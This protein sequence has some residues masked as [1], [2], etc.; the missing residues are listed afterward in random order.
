MEFKLKKKVRQRESVNLIF[1]D[2][3]RD[4]KELKDSAKE[5]R[6]AKPKQ[7]PKPEAINPVTVTLTELRDEVNHQRMLTSLHKSKR[8][9]CEETLKQV[10]EEL[11]QS[12]LQVQRLASQIEENQKNYERQSRLMTPSKSSFSF[13]MK[14]NEKDKQA[15]EL[16]NQIKELMKLN[17]Q[18]STSLAQLSHSKFTVNPEYESVKVAKNRHQ[19]EMK[20][21]LEER[22]H[23]F[24]QIKK[25][26]HRL[27]EYETQILRLTEQAK[28]SA[29]HDDRSELSEEVGVHAL[30]QHLL[31]EKQTRQKLQHALV[32]LN[33]EMQTL[34]RK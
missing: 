19:K 34:K 25:M 14:K 32:E 27:Q 15:E 21:L 10:Q 13:L 33:S 26:N 28:Q 1:S 24:D 22:Q 30:Y 7:E 2:S 20:A 18:H 29:R 16:Q 9:E 12:N 31:R 5:I 6:V 3:A 17:E 8:M 4:Q 23:D 11:H